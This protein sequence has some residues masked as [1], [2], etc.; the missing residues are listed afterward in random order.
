[1]I[2][3]YHGTTDEAAPQIDA[4]GF[5]DQHYEGAG[6]GVWLSTRPYPIPA[7]ETFIEVEIPEELAMRTERPAGA[8]PL[9]VF[10]V[11]AEELNACPR[12]TLS[13]AESEDLSV[14]AIEIVEAVEGAPRLDKFGQVTPLRRS[15]PSRET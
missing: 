1:M 7:P 4:S 14:E 3:V 10:L 6:T 2:L 13:R 12:R 8:L 9:R 5:A 15:R 11:P